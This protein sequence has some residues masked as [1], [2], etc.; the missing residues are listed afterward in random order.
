MF[1]VYSISDVIKLRE[2]IS[3]AR[4]TAKGSSLRMKWREKMIHPLLKA[5]RL[6]TWKIRITSFACNSSPRCMRCGL[7]NQW[8][9]V[10]CR[11]LQIIK[12][13]PNI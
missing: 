8:S 9:N 12:L 10:D 5:K 4:V 11:F 13:S 7:F 6:S 2:I 1:R 3:K